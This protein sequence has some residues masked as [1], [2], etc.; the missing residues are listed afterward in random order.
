MPLLLEI[1]S[2]VVI[3]KSGEDEPD[4]ARTVRTCSVE[5][6]L[7]LAPPPIIAGHENPSARDS[8]S[9]KGIQF[10]MILAVRI[11]SGRSVTCGSLV[12]T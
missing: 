3:I 6:G 1:S 8:R 12:D 11:I 2:D 10:I 9:S 7:H 5:S 4:E